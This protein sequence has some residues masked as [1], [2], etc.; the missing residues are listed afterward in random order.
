MAT[1]SRSGSNSLGT[2]GGGGPPGHHRRL[3]SNA[4]A[5]AVAERGD[6]PYRPSA[7]PE[8]DTIYSS[9]ARSMHRVQPFELRKLSEEAT[10]KLY[11]NGTGHGR[12]TS[13]PPSPWSTP[14]MDKS[15]GPRSPRFA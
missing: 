15:E 8:D 4:A 6:Y 10:Q 11:F 5:A 1:S 7:Q 2:S 3:P 9:E 13:V 14:S 12:N